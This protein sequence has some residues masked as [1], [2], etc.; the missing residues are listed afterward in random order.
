MS[1][2]LGSVHCSSRGFRTIGLTIGYY[3]YYYSLA[4]LIYLFIFLIPQPLVVPLDAF[5]D[6]L[7]HGAQTRRYRGGLG[8]A[9]QP[10]PWTRLHRP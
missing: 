3:Y 4:R 9:F 6:R 1:T 5:S 8:L 10:Q 7:T 2:T